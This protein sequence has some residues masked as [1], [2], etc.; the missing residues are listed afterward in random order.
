MLFISVGFIFP[1]DYSELQIYLYLFYLF[2]VAP[3]KWNSKCCWR[4]QTSASLRITLVLP[5]RSN[6]PE[7]AGTIK[8]KTGRGDFFVVPHEAAPGRGAAA[9]GS[10]GQ[11]TCVHDEGKT[12]RCS[13]SLSAGP[14]LLFFFR[15]CNRAVVATRTYPSLSFLSL[16]VPCLP[17]PLGWREDGR[18]QLPAGT[19]PSTHGPCGRGQRAIRH[20][21]LAARST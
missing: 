7:L 1:P 19:T 2:N 16:G 14:L 3:T 10:T 21:L 18:N 9:R 8:G 11:G 12:E 6:K 20:T 4:C 13:V 15:T 17:I 5:R